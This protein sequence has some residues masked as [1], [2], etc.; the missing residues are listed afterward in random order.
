MPIAQAH[1]KPIENF[2]G[3]EILG[4]VYT[5]RKDAGKAIINACTSLNSSDPVRLGQYRGFSLSLQYD[6]AHTDYK[7]TLKGHLSH[8]ISLSADAG[9]NI[10]RMDNAVDG[11]EKVLADLREDLQDVKIQLANAKTE[12]EAPSQRKQSWPKNPHG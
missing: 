8:T 5:E 3:M 12:M 2:A 4:T 11:L 10:I 7:L 1:P 6:A 9:G